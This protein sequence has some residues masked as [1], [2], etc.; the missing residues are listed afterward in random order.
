MEQQQE[1]TE[2]NINN[3]TWD[4][5]FKSPVTKK[6]QKKDANWSLERWIDAGVW[7]KMIKEFNE[8]TIQSDK[9]VDTIIDSEEHADA[10]NWLRN[11]ST[12]HVDAK[13][14]YEK[15]VVDGS[16]QKSDPSVATHTTN[17]TSA[18][19]TT[20]RI[21]TEKLFINPIIQAVV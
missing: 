18:T 5:S 6:V 13:S 19:N 12:K 16:D 20:N 11:D 2:N 4:T 1:E 14:D 9:Q 17:G 3:I 21:S 7:D 8:C 10:R 15:L